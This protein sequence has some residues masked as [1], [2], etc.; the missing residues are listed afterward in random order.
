MIHSKVKDLPETIQAALRSIGYHR[1]DI[2]IEGRQDIDPGVVGG[3]GRKGF[4]MI[5][6]M[7]TGEKKTLFGSWGGSNMFNSGNQV[8]NDRKSYDI[9]PNFCVIKGSIGD[10]TYASMYIRP[11]N[12]VMFLPAK[13]ELEPRDRWLLYTFDALTSP[14]HKDEWRRRNDPPSEDDLNRLASL[15]YL[16]RAKNGATSITTDGKNALGRKAGETI[17]HPSREW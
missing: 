10:K 13:V 2:T 11:S 1:Q 15:G 16:K 4:C 14:G 12:M 5:V 17:R 9:P 7:T 3:A 8:D 6:N